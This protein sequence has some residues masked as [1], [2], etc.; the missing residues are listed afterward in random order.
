MG[1]RCLEFFEKK[2]D[3]LVRVDY[4]YHFSASVDYRQRVQIVLVEELGYVGLMHVGGTG[5][6]AGFS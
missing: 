3:H 2:T 4:A 5:A 6:N 1:L